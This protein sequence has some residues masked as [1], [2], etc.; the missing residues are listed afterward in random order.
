[1]ENLKPMHIKRFV[2]HLLTFRHTVYYRIWFFC[3]PFR[4][5]GREHHKTSDKPPPA[6][7][8]SR[9]G[10]LYVYHTADC[11]PLWCVAG[12]VVLYRTQR[13]PLV[14]CRS[15]PNVQDSQKFL[16]D[17][18]D[19]TM[20]YRNNGQI[21]EELQIRFTG[22]LIQAVKRTRRDYLNMLNQYSNSEI[23]TDTT[24]TT[25]QTLEQEVTEHLPLWDV[26]ESNA[27]F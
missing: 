9:D 3:R 18:E 27:L 26:I 16:N 23:L 1:M 20:R 12:C 24:Y 6:G 21:E 25:G 14:R 7:V 5:T 11:S 10:L 15:P 13:R 22:Y 19:K 8:G 17:L 4:R 2:A